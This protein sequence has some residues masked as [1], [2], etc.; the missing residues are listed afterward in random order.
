MTQAERRAFLIGRLLEEQPRHRDVR[1]P[2]D[3][4]G[5]RALLR[6]LMNV[7]PAAPIGEDFL[8]AQDAYLREEIA[9][10]GVTLPLAGGHH[11]ACL[12]RDRQRGQQRHDGLL[13]A[14]SQ[15]H[16]QLHPYVRGRAAARPVRRYHGASG[17]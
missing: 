1:V 16:R 9:G 7:R 4:D 3:D 2:A 13:P 5:Q 14:L 15:L 11:D 8:A 12:R 10:R 6:S 17:L